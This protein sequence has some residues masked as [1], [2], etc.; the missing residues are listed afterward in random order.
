MPT[1]RNFLRN[2][3]SYGN[4]DTY[5]RHVADPTPRSSP[6]ERDN[7]ARLEVT[8]NR[9]GHWTRLRNNEELGDVDQRR[10]GTGLDYS[11]AMCVHQ[12]RDFE[13]GWLT[14]NIMTHRLTG[15][16]VQVGKVSTKGMT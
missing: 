1:G 9:A 6:A 10:K 12:G 13:G 11:L 3:A 15:T 5:D 14:I 8:N 16:S 7:C 2:D 4:H